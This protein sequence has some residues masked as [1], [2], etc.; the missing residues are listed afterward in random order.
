MGF[1]NESLSDG[2]L[3]DTSDAI[4]IYEVRVKD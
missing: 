2:E 3:A 1:C 4:L